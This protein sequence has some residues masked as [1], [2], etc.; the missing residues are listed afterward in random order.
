MEK[1][2]GLTRG[3]SETSMFYKHENGKHLIVLT[4]VDDLVYTGHPDLIAQ[5][6]SKLKSKWNVQQCEDLTSGMHRT[7][8]LVLDLTLK[9]INL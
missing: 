9:G 1:E 6:E 3:K 7:Q 2:C 4:E 8:L 5:F